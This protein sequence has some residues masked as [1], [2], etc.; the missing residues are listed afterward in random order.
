MAEDG[1]QLS[2]GSLL[3][4]EERARANLSREGAIV[5][6]KEVPRPGVGFSGMS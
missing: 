1:E 3:S 6:G 4:S 2:S 5:E